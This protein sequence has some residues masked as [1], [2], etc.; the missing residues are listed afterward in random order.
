MRNVW[1]S[2][3]E[4]AGMA[5]WGPGWPS[6]GW[7]GRWALGGQDGRLDLGVRAYELEGAAAKATVQGV[8]RGHDTLVIVEGTLWGFGPM[9]SGSTGGTLWRG[10]TLGSSLGVWYPSHLG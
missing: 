1:P 8:F 6:G 10:G 9:T 2:G 3:F 4:G 7:D 5:F